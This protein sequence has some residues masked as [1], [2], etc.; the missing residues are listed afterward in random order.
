MNVPFHCYVLDTLTLYYH[1]CIYIYIM[2][3]PLLSMFQLQDVCESGLDLDQKF[4]VELNQQHAGMT[5]LALAAALNKADLC[6]VRSNLRH[7]VSP[8]YNITCV[9]KLYE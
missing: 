5:P 3:N 8:H 2:F 4:P 1:Y 7:T 6:Q 9:V